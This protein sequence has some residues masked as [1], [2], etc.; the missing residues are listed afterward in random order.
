MLS[1]LERELKR[2]TE[3]NDKFKDRSEKIDQIFKEN[4]R[5]TSTL[6]DKINEI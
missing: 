1:N 5:L 6:M 2:I 4:K 3:E